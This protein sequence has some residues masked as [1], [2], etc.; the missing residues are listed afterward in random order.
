MDFGSTTYPASTWEREDR[1]AHN[2]P[3]LDPMDPMD[4]PESTP[5]PPPTAQELF[6]DRQQDLR[7]LRIKMNHHFKNSKE[8]KELGRV[9][10]AEMEFKLGLGLA[11]TVIVQSRND[12]A[13]D[14]EMTPDAYAAETAS[15]N[16]SDDEPSTDVKE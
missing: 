9:E 7:D 1:K 11:W 2:Q 14:G 12:K 5:S 10:E 8:L 3:D 13:A 16:E 6:G 15:E 4:V